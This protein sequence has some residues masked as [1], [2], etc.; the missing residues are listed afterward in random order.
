MFYVHTITYYHTIKLYR[1]NKT[2]H[3]HV[4]QSKNEKKIELVARNAR[5][6]QQQQQKILVILIIT[7][8]KFICTAFF[9]MSVAVAA[10]VVKLLSNSWSVC[11]C[12]NWKWSNEKLM[13]I[14]SLA[15]SLPLSVAHHRLFIC[16]I[17]HT[18]WTCALVAANEK[19]DKNHD[20]Q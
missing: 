12:E 1:R 7:S 4:R 14:F 8:I 19:I 3:F 18:E 13:C 5:K 20:T 6:W 16:M 15:L 17:T 2:R 10:C 11:V 9:Y